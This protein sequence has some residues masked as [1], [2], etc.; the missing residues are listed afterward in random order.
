M[1]CYLVIAFFDWKIGVF[2]QTLVRVYYILKFKLLALEMSF[3]NHLKG[4]TCQ[5]WNPMKPI[6]LFN[7]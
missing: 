6:E 3:D 7:T 5:K 4:N 1:W 2:Q